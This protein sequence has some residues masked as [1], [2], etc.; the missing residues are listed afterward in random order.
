ML[1]LPG[2]TLYAPRTNGRHPAIVA[3]PGAGI[4]PAPWFARRGIAFFALNQNAEWRSRTFDDIADD[5][6]EAV[7]M[8]HSRS[9]ID[10]K[11]IG[12]YASSQG[13]WTAPIAAS[14]STAIAF[15]VCVACPATDLNTQ[16]L[17]RA[18]AEL[19]AHRRQRVGPHRTFDECPGD[20]QVAGEPGILPTLVVAQRDRR[21]VEHARLR[22]AG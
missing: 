8:L 5:V 1:Q 17:I 12:I 19:R 6:V 3:I 16:E 20:H 2:G 4:L 7:K 18:E 9:D 22:D 10:S 21:L 14:K 11:K 13:G 15:V